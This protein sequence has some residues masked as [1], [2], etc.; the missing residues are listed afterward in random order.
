MIDIEFDF[1]TDSPR[2]WDGFWERND[3]LRYGESNPDIVSPTLQ[4]YHKILWGK[5]LPNGEVMDLKT[6]AGPYYLTWKNFRFGS[7]SIIVSLRYKK[8]R[9]M[10]DQV[11]EKV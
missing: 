9:Y 7:D 8:Y 11:R 1:T 2:Y 6:G 3:G 10:I 5:P 4:K